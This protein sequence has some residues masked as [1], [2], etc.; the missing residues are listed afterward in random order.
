M[1]ISSMAFAQL[2]V[3]V[4]TTSVSVSGMCDLDGFGAGDS[5]PKWDIDVSDNRDYDGDFVHEAG[6]NN[7][8]NITVNS[9]YDNSLNFNKAYSGIC[10]PAFLNID[11][12][13]YENDPFGSEVRF[14]QSYQW[15]VPTTPGTYN[16]TR[17]GNVSG[18][19]GTI[20]W[21][22]N[23]RMTISGVPDYE[24]ADEPCLASTQ[25]IQ[26]PCD[27][28]LIY[29]RYDV[30]SS[31]MTINNSSTT[32]GIDGDN[33][34][35]FKLQAPPSGAVSIRV[36]DWGDFAAF[37]LADLTGNI[38]EGSCNALNI[39]GSTENVT[40]TSGSHS[41]DCIDFSTGL[42]NDIN[43]GPFVLD[44]LTVGQTYYMRVTEEDD[45]S[46]YI[47]LAFVEIP[48]EDNCINA[49]YLNGIGC[50]YNA[51]AVNEPDFNQWTGQSHTDGR[52]VNGDGIMD[53]IDNCDNNWSSNENMVWYYFD[54][55]DITVQPITITVNSIDCND[56]GGGN[57]QMGIWKENGGSCAV[58]GA[59]SA[60]NG[61]GSMVPVGCSVG[62]SGIVEV[63]LP[64]DMPNDRYY[65]VV[66]GDAGAECRWVFESLEVL[67]VE[68]DEF[69]GV[70]RENENVLDWRTLSETNNSH[71]EVQRSSDP[72]KEFETIGKV[73]GK[74]TSSNPNS[75]FFT[76]KAPANSSY[77]RLKQVDFDGE[78]E[79][80]EVIHILRKDAKFD[81]SKVYPSP[82][83]T[84]VN[85]KF[86]THETTSLTLTITDMLGRLVSM[87]TIDAEAGIQIKELDV[88]HL[89]NG[90]YTVTLDDGVTKK[91]DKIIK[92]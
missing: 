86:V 56:T 47:D 14:D 64:D 41:T 34:I 22:I 69:N 87:E 84:L 70:A 42:F 29:Q 15:N 28:T 27:A 19:S 44:G 12:S 76:D 18:C 20:T 21:T 40:G 58:A 45:Q 2:N 55:D 5:D 61:L 67:P 90:V 59:A 60:A 63:T 35:F 68:M 4:T 1:F 54:I 48:P 8:P 85:I 78:Y 52:D 25:E 79:Y 53:D 50:N 10:P 30:S 13:G 17:T 43:N 7:G 11:W 26:D 62:P 91:V 6:G 82:A 51:T 72:T 57:M 24:C 3:Q 73:E 65:V 74:G 92:Q 83:S 75:Y 81:I 49:Q 71:F 32:C 46:A 38:F 66:D 16:L 33:D 37:E 77:Y 36:D 89:S 88:T 31:N 23:L 39:A 9:G 80:T